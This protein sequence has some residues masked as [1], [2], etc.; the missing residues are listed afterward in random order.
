MATTIQ[1]IITE[2]ESLASSFVPGLGS[3]A[4]IAKLADDGLS[5]VSQPIKSAQLDKPANEAK[6]SNRPI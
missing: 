5:L 4:T 2:A 6:D 3:A 1:T